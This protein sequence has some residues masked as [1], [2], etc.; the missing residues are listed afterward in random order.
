MNT[1]LGLSLLALAV[2]VWFVIWPSIN[3]IKSLKAIA[4]Q[5]ENLEQIMKKAAMLSK[6]LNSTVSQTNG[7]Y[8]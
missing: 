8:A 2:L 4:E 7:W 6:R 3:E 1:S 5:Q